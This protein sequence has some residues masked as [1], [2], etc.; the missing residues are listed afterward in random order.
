M[1]LSFANS[2]KFDPS[3]LKQR[4][5][6]VCIDK[7]LREIINASLADGI[8]AGRNYPSGQGARRRTRLI[9]WGVSPPAAQSTGAPEC[10]RV[11]ACAEPALETRKPVNAFA[12]PGPCR[13]NGSSIAQFRK[14]P[15]ED[16]PRLN[17]HAQGARHGRLEKR[18]EA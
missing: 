11:A 16:V 17:R 3:P 8:S 1:K 18:T 2:G 9:C 14:W 5:R 10:T 15:K 12:S 4:A 13:N 6:M 7:G